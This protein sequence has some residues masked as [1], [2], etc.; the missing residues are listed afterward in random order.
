MRLWGLLFALL[1]P[2]V[3]LGQIAL[4]KGPLLESSSTLRQG[5]VAAWPLDELSGTRRD[6]SKNALNLS[7]SN[8]PPGIPSMVNFGGLFNAASQQILYIN[9]N[10]S[11]LQFPNSDFTLSAWVTLYQTNI[12]QTIVSKNGSSLGEYSLYF[13]PSVHRFSFTLWNQGSIVGDLQANTFGAPIVGVPYH[14]LAWQVVASNKTYLSV[15]GTVDS[16]TRTGTNSVTT[17]TLV[18]GGRF[19]LSQWMNGE[20]DNVCIWNRSLTTDERASLDNRADWPRF[21]Q[22]KY[23][24]SSN[25]FTQLASMPGIKQQHGMEELGGLIYAVAGIGDNEGN[26]TNSVF[27]YDPGTD[28]W[29]TKAVLP[30]KAQSGVLRAVSGKLYWI[31]G[32]NH[33]ANSEFTNSYAYDPAANTWT[34]KAQ[35]PLPVEDMAS[36]V[37]SNKI[38]ISGGIRTNSPLA[39]CTLTQVYDPSNDTWATN[40]TVAPN[41]RALGDR[42]CTQSNLFYVVSGTADVSTYS[43]TGFLNASTRVDRY[44]P[45]G[46]SWAQLASCPLSVC[47]TEVEEVGG[48]LYVFG[49]MNFIVGKTFTSAV[50]RYDPVTDTWSYVARTPLTLAAVATAK[51]GSDI[52]V[53]GGADASLVY[54]TFYK[55]TP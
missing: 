6:W 37:I 14:L 11:K 44:D 27:A 15:N 2:L 26:E 36:C 28:T 53:S 8:S 7:Q 32:Y 38:Y 9:G 29:A 46:D 1:L 47:Y 41:P 16:F 55:F 34:A 23:P 43:S 25:K 30:I 19:G 54:S 4:N 31:A 5:L 21:Q 50:Q 49:G 52:Y 13:D 51:L 20:I 18:V 42:G 10:N 3:S 33:T 17:N 12:T 48:Y 24:I 40:L 35:M 22:I 45:V 39:I